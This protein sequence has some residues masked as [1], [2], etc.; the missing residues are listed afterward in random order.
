MSG[1][2]AKE[3][4]EPRLE[5]LENYTGRQEPDEGLWW[6]MKLSQAELEMY[7]VH[8]VLLL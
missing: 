1:D 6:W 8:F 7:A 3:T 4:K 2:C 5:R